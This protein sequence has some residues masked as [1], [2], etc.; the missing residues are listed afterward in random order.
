MKFDDTDW[1]LSFPQRIKGGGEIA[2]FLLVVFF[3][4]LKGVSGIQRNFP[5]KLR[6]FLSYFILFTLQV[7][8]LINNK[9]FPV[10]FS[11]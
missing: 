4:V 9:I 1:N 11:F 10:L 7:L 5:L 2:S 8:A 3:V 6:Y